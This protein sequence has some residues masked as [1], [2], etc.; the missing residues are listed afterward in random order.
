MKLRKEPTV[1]E[2]VCET[3]GYPMDSGEVAFWDECDVPFCSKS[4]A[5]SFNL[6][7]EL[8]EAERSS[9]DGQCRL[10]DDSSEVKADGTE[11]SGGQ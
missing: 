10:V 4:C 9:W 8:W 6:R 2:T 11:G 7:R 3:C 1:E 5:R